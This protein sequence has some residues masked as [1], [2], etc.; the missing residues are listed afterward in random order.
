MAHELTLQEVRKKITEKNFRASDFLTKEQVDEV[1]KS[2][3]KGKK[4]THYNAVDAYIAEIIARFGY[5]TYI[6]WKDGEIN[7][8]TMVKFIEAERA[9]E[10]ARNLALEAIIVAGLAGAQQPTKSGQTPKSLKTAIKILTR[11]QDKAKGEI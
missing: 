3:A 6:A 8:D 1:K 9:R 2:N 7:E 5:N 10:V 4:T 11:E